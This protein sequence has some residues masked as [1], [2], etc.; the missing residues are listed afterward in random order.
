MTMQDMARCIFIGVTLAFIMTQ[1]TE[2]QGQ[3]SRTGVCAHRELIEEV[4]GCNRDFIAK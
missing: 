3:L 1:Y 4:T 2:S